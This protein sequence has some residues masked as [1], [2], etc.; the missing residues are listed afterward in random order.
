MPTVT[1]QTFRTI[2]R[3]RVS[4]EIVE[5]VQDLI[6]SGRLRTGD[7]LPPE[8]DLAQTF[9]VSRSSVREAIRALESLGLVEVR[10]GE[11]TFLAEPPTDPGG[12]PLTGRR[13]KAWDD[14]HK[15]FEVRRVIEPDLAALAARR[16]TAGHIEQMR[17]ALEE[18][19]GEIQQGRTGIQADTR[20]HM[21]LAAATGNAILLQIMRSLLGRLRKS[22]ESSLQGRGRPAQ[23]LEQHQAILQAI[24]ARD[25]KLA[26]QQ[27]LEHIQAMEEFALLHTVWFE[28]GP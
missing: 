27:M 14:Q 10:A 25:P 8:R 19:K 16:A 17:V 22:R 18:L 3:S 28:V 11:G 21:L 15:L 26:E 13:R 9:H 24:E 23:S 4:Q 5:Q 1:R 12:V 20:F 6:T 2:R 7:R